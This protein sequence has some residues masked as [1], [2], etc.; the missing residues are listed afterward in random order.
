MGY[1]A[2]TAAIA[3]TIRGHARGPST[4]APPYLLSLAYLAV[5]GSVIAFGAYLTLL[6]RV[7]AGRR[8]SSRRRRR[9]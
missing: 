3:A 6:K 8:P 1:G 2:L 4:R 7:G 9:P 5:F